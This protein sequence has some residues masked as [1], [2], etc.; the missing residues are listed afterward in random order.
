EIKK[1]PFFDDGKMLGS[2]PFQMTDWVKGESWTMTANKDYWGGAP[3]I[4]RFIV[5]HYNNP[6][7]MAS[8][9]KTGEIDYTAT[10]TPSLFRSIASENGSNGLTAHVGP[11]NGF[12][13]MSFNMCDPTAAD[14][15][16]YCKKTGR[17]GNP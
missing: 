2:G 9:L 16:P 5:R 6:E 15:A 7:A 17:T 10:A 3:Q 1:D 11:V 8:A 12:D 13:Q 4:D 14:A